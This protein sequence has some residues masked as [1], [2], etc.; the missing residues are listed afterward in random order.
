MNVEPPSRCEPIEHVIE[1]EQA[2]E[3][4]PTIADLGLRKRACGLDVGLIGEPKPRIEI[5]GE[6]GG[7]TSIK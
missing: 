6:D 4:G 7:L 3:R 1:A 2:A 5:A